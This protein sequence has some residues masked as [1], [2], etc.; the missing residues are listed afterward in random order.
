VAT[1]SSSPRPLPES[2][3]LVRAGAPEMKTSPHRP[4]A[5][6][7][8]PSPSS[9][10][11]TLIEL[12][13]VI[14]IIAVLIALLLPAVQA[15]REAARRSQCINNLKQIGIGLHNYHV[16]NDCFPQGSMDKYAPSKP[17]AI[18][19]GDCSANVRMLGFLEQQALYNAANFQVAFINDTI[20]V[21]MNSTVTTARLNTF[22]CPSCPAP[23]WKMNATAPLSQYTAPGTNYFCSA[24]SCLEFLANYVGG[25]PNGVF[26]GRAAGVIGIRDI[27]D[28]TA[29]TIAYGEWRT[30]S[31]NQ[32]V[33]TIP[34]DIIFMN[35][36]PSGVSRTTPGTELMPMP[37]GVFQQWINDCVAVVGAPA[38]RAGNTVCL[39]QNW[40]IGLIGFTLGNLLLPPNAPYPSC[41]TNVQ[42]QGGLEAPAILGLSSL[43][44]GGANVLMCDGSVKFLKSSLNQVTLW[45][46]GSRNQG[47]VVSADSY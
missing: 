1:P 8:G 28:G 20:A 15:A 2:I 10:A 26:Q 35:T 11:F 14:A 31:G 9:P 7:P 16:A 38:N 41:S 13:V 47:E 43:H 19:N 45:A 44:P 17:Q 12:L 33:V 5:G 22:L 4:R 32:S 40:A 37:P 36:F 29:N 18:P 39:G 23:G 34:T 6:R 21:P 27:V 46:I 24:G 25:P 30:G 3:D 42:S